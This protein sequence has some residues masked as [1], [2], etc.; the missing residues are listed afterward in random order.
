MLFYLNMFYLFCKFWQ[1]L[2]Y[3]LVYAVKN[4]TAR[5]YL[6]MINRIKKVTQKGQNG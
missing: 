3:F 1:N 5:A 4:I 6:K 2:R